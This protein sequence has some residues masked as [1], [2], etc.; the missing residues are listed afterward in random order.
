MITDDGFFP[1]R[2]AII[3][4]GLMGGSLA[5]ALRG[6]CKKLLAVDNNSATIDLARRNGIVDQI[7]D[8]LDEIL[9]QADVIILAVP[10][11]SII[12]IIGQLATY[13]KNQ[14]IVFDLGSTKESICEAM[15][16][17]PGYLTPIGGH[18]MCGRE[19]NGL[20]HA[21]A[22][23]FREATFALVTC[24]NTTQPAKL[25]A[26][27]IVHHIKARPLWIDAKTHDEW[28]AATSHLQY[29]LSTAL[30][31][32]TP[33][34]AAPLIGPGFESTTRLASSSAQVMEDIL[35]T[36]K[37]NVLDSLQK[38]RETLN[39]LTRNLEDESG[40]LKENLIGTADKRTALLATK[41][42]L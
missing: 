30:I 6:H 4:L 10:I 27:S 42:Q 3:G 8:Q 32:A 18:P 15:E 22:D 9:P 19:T 37:T 17:L 35:T 16:K 11:K 33:E 26:E 20:E 23:I 2:I 41:Q 7:S 12:Q 1:A 34:A 5:L 29:L 28:T 40:Q 24:S 21:S 13:K 31:Q 25:M 38:F 36:N 39:I 14:A